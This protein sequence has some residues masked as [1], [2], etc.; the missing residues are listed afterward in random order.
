MHQA[1]RPDGQKKTRG[2]PAAV[3]VNSAMTFETAASRPEER[4]RLQERKK[5]LLLSYLRAFH[6]ARDR[7]QLF[8]SLHE[9]LRTEFGADEVRFASI[10]P[11]KGLL[12]YQ[13]PESLA[14][15]PL[16]G[17]S[18]FPG[19]D[20]LGTPDRRERRQ[21]ETLSVILSRDSRLI[22]VV[23]LSRWG[24]PFDAGERL[25]LDALAPHMAIALN[26]FLLSEEAEFR[27]RIEGR[28][29]SALRRLN[30]SLDLDEILQAILDHLPGLLA[31]DWAAIFVANQGEFCDRPALRGDWEDSEQ[32]LFERAM[33][34][35]EYWSRYGANL[36]VLSSERPPQDDLRICSEAQSEVQ[37]P[38]M[39]GD[40]L[41]G[42]FCLAS[43]EGSAYA[44]DEVDLLQAFA[45]QASLAIERARLHQSM[46]EKSQL[47]QEVR[48]ARE[49]QLRFLPETMPSIPG[50]DL[51]A[52]NI[53]SQ[54]VS[55]DY[56]DVIPISRGQWGLVMGDVS[57]KGYA[58]GLI[59]SAFRAALLAEIRNNFD[60]GAILSKVNCLLWEMTNVHR[61]VTAFY[62]VFDAEKGLLTYSN[63][64][65]NPPLLLRGDGNAEWL[66][67]GGLLLGAFETASYSQHRI[68]LRSGDRLLLYT[69][70][71]SESLD[72]NGRE[73]GIDGLERLLREQQ[74]NGLTA[75]EIVDE[76]AREALRRSPSG[77]PGDDVTLL[78][79][80]MQ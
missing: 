34:L 58:A 52:A 31:C 11:R 71:L 13:Y 68:E 48:I 76:L 4:S 17:E 43:R 44:M 24:L 21:L 42:I 73:L 14:G 49:I 41:V 40:Q 74:G 72:G 53:A 56:Y 32:T 66:E 65:H 75:Q 55:G 16:G 28:L 47:E 9:L 79:L 30:A 22:G 51:G 36:Q 77:I 8:S 35:G 1:E 54:T 67:E 3:R 19:S 27:A 6:N 20:G 50:V 64:G 59:M 45:D 29:K 60:I 57:G 38:L 25:Y 12:S 46:L 2:C 80:R 33:R 37:I 7:N 5:E 26:H 15:H 63:A 18:G 69:D 10:D 61:Y 78:A 23:E 39:N 70:G 62:G